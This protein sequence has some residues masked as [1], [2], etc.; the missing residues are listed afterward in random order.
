M[1]RQRVQAVLQ[2]LLQ[3]WRLIALLAVLVVLTA[4]GYTVGTRLATSMEI[5]TWSQF[6]PDCTGG[7]PPGP[8]LPPPCPLPQTP[9]KI[10]DAT[11]T[12]L[13]LVQ[14]LQAQLDR[15]VVQGQYCALDYIGRHNH[16]KFR[17]ATHG[18]TT[19]VYSGTDLCAGW[20]S[21]TL[22]IFTDFWSISGHLVNVYGDRLD[23]AYMFDALHKQIGMPLPAWWPPPTPQYSS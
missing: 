12:N 16:Y 17:F 14:D 6:T 8:V 22:G 21:V 4:G 9:V 20:D 13:G 15:S 7:P 19:Q 3:H 5:I 10:F 18:V 23:G 11:L 2:K 1:L